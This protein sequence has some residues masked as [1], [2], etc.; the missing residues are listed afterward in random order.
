MFLLMASSDSRVNEGDKT[1]SRGAATIKS[2]DHLQIIPAIF[3]NPGYPVAVAYP[4]TSSIG[5]G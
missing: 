4:N 3:N 2:K 1:G 5:G